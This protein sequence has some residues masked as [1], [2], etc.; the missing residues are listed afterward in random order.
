[1]LNLKSKLKIYKIYNTIISILVII[2]LL[3][4]INSRL[5]INQLANKMSDV[6]NKLLH[7]TSSSYQEFIKLRYD[8][9]IRQLKSEIKVLKNEIQSLKSYIDNKIDL[10]NNDNDESKSPPD[11]YD[12]DDDDLSDI[13]INYN[14][15]EI[16]GL[17]SELYTKILSIIDIGYGLEPHY[18]IISESIYKYESIYHVNGIFIISVMCKMINQRTLKCNN[19]FGLISSNGKTYRVYDTY[20][21]SIEY[22]AKLMRNRYFD[23]GVLT[24]SDVAKIYLPHNSSSWENAINENILLIRNILGNNGGVL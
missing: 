2:A 10:L 11:D 5:T 13:I 8:N 7:Q 22:F 14:I 18:K 1:M 16:S 20:Q 21:D 15:D 4:Y 6:N 23:N 9:E 24:V 19:L 12:D 3:M 17:S